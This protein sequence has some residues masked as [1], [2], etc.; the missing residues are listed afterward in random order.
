MNKKS[1]KKSVLKIIIDAIFGVVLVGLLVVIGIS[2]IEKK[3]NKY[4]GKYHLTWIYTDSMDPI[5]KPQ[6]YILTK[7]V[8]DA[9]VEVN[10]GDIITFLVND[11]ES[12]IYGKYNT[13]QVIDITEEGKYI[14]KGCHNLVADNYEVVPGDVVA[15]YVKNLPVFTFF[16]RLFASE[17]GFV[18]TITIIVGLTATWFV[19]DY[20]QRKK[21]RLMEE[22]VKE[23]VER[24][25]KEGINEKK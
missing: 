2:I 21:E 13:H 10:K 18:V 4:V 1:S 5:I 8:N 17:A 24:L 22:L 19:I 11:P 12:D 15:K 9:S 14:T 7:K 16:G 6:S 20:K 25:K 3:T 23:E